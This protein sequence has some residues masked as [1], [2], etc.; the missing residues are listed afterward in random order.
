MNIIIPLGG[1]GERFTNGYLQPKPLI[2]ILEKC[3]IEHVLDNI[4]YNSDDHV[5]IIYNQALIEHNF[6]ERII[7]KY[8]HINLIQLYKNTKGAA[9]TLQVGIKQILSKKHNQKCLILDCDTFYRQDIVNLFRNSPDNMIFYTE[10]T[11]PTPLYSYISLDVSSGVIQIKEKQKISDNANTGAYA[12]TNISELYYYCNYV[13]EHG[14]T[15]NNEPYTSCVISEM[16]NS[17]IAFKGYKLEQFEVVSLGTPDDVEKYIKST[18]LLLFDLDGTLVNTDA[19]YIAV[20]SELLATFNINCNADFFN[21]FIKGKNDNAFLKYLNHEFSETDIQTISSKKDEL[22]LSKLQ[23]YENTVL[24]EGAQS[25]FEK[26]KTHKVAIVTSSN[27]KACNYIL[28]ITGLNKYVD[29]VIAAEDCGKH[30]PDPEP[31][32]TAIKHFNALKEN[33]FI[34]E[35]SYSGYCSAK[36]SSIDNICLILNGQSCSDIQNADDFKISNYTTLELDSIVKFHDKP[37]NIDVDYLVE[38]KHNINTFPIKR[39]TQNKECIKTGYICDIIGYTVEYNNGEDENVI[40][41]ISN[42]ENELSETALKLDMYKNE[43]YFYTNLSHLIKNVPKYM[44]H[45]N[46]NDKEAIILENLNKYVGTFNI[47]LNKNIQI[48][49]NIVNCIFNLHITFHFVSEDHIISAIKP[50]KKI[51]EISYY[52]EFILNRFDKFAKNTH[53]LLSKSERNLL[54]NIFANIDTIYD[55]VSQYPLSVCHGDLKSPNIFYK[56]NIDP[57][58]LDWQYIHL[59]KG[60]SDIV[61]LLVESVEFDRVTVEIVVNYYYKLNKET[62]DITY[63]EYMTDFKNALCVFPFFVCV[64]FNSEDSDKLLDPIFPI[65]FLKNLMKY[66]NHFLTPNH[67]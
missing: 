19:I 2:P 42:L 49:L 11:N 39:I 52:K 63:E 26:N 3:M 30:K 62:Y 36:R 1:K 32:L 24:I 4:S 66:Y 16:L 46:V 28:Q 29:L 61:F 40:L 45:F 17:Q 59:N 37:G 5:F 47:N 65:R 64:W 51:N 56:N 41:K 44:G 67:I 22:F 50:L 13:L 15:T 48:L 23:E 38:L 8:P 54:S 55:A 12:F 53:T 60:V 31:Y 14:I 43:S 9:E 10:S 25:F 27:R 33:T 21:H 34:F 58:L 35:D 18:N 57:I 6:R 20:W 7:A